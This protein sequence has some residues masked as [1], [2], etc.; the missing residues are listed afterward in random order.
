MYSTILLLAA[1]WAALAVI[2]SLVL[3]PLLMSARM[4][5]ELL[6]E[7]YEEPAWDGEDIKPLSRPGW[8]DPDW[9]LPGETA[10]QWA[11]RRGHFVRAG[12][13]ARR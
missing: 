4:S 6:G 5:D 2:A 7:P 1:A 10:E 8:L 9:V 3:W 13:S 12:A 11:R